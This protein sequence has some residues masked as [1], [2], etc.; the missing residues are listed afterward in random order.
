MCRVAG[1]DPSVD[2]NGEE[3]SG[4]Q[5]KGEL[6][7]HGITEKEIFLH[8]QGETGC[9]GLSKVGL[10]CVNT[11]D[12]LS[13][14]KWC[15]ESDVLHHVAQSS[16]DQQAKMETQVPLRSSPKKSEICSDT[17]AHL[18]RFA[19]STS[20]RSGCQIMRISW[21][22]SLGFRLTRFSV[23]LFAS[24]FSLE[25]VNTIR[26]YQVHWELVPPMLEDKA[27]Q[28]GLMCHH[29]IKRQLFQANWS[30]PRDHAEPQGDYCKCAAICIR[31]QVPYT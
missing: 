15:K 12:L 19:A 16:L 2:K 29:I 30:G 10:T 24:N 23:C 6:H 18:G 20:A 8:G 7:D 21:R 17:W 13:W 22:P 1:R 3:Q 4:S 5:P 27:R 9:D 25:Q 11:D 26:S 14:A 31:S 28:T